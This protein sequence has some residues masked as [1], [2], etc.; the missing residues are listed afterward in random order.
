MLD[1]EYFMEQALDEAQQAYAAGEFPVGCVIVQD[2]EIISRGCRA[3]TAGPSGSF[4][5]VDH[6]EMTALRRLEQSGTRIIPEKTVVFS[7]MEPCL[8]CYGA[9]VIS[10]IKTVV[11]AYEDPMGGA[12]KGDYSSFPPL[13][14]NSEMTIIP[15]VLRQKS[16]DLFYDF[17]NKEKN[18]YWKDS[19]LEQY[20][21]ECHK[22]AG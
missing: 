6:A 12:T 17:F 15:G 14:K 7:T 3:G 13:Y 8:M 9:I 21:R 4:G 22:G 19:L 18:Q 1:Y 20:T 5:E 16:L 11:Y 10:G 2:G